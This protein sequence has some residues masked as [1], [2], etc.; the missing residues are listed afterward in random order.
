MAGRL[1]I[2]RSTNQIST[3]IWFVERK[4]DG[5][6]AGMARQSPVYRLSPY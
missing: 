6:H 4:K 3:E 2:L 1:Q 5:Y